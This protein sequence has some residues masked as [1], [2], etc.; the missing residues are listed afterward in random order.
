MSSSKRSSRKSSSRSRSKSKSEPSK[1]YGPADDEVK[2]GGFFPMMIGMTASLMLLFWVASLFTQ[3]ASEKKE[4][5]GER[6]AKVSA[7]LLESTSFDQFLKDANDDQVVARLNQL[8]NSRSPK[9]SPA[10]V[11]ESN[12]RILLC[13]RLLRKKSSKKYKKFAKL[14]WIDS[15]KSKYG[16]DFLGKMN[17]P[18]VSEEFE[19]CFSR[20]LNDTDQEVYREAH[21]ARVSHVL[22]ECIKG[23]R[24]A[25]DVSA[26]LSDTLKKFPGDD[27]VASIIRLQFKAAVE[28]D[29]NFAKQLAEDIL[30]KDGL[31]DEQ[32]AG[33]MQFV[34]DHYQIIKLNYDEMFINRFVNG[35]VGLRELQ[36]TSLQL[37]SNPEGGPLVVNKVS[38]VASWFER[39]R[40]FEIASEI[41]QAMADASQQKR[42]VAETNTLLDRIG[43]AGVKRMS[44]IGQEIP[45]SGK[46]LAGKQI[47]SGDFKGRV[48]LA[49]FFKPNQPQSTRM[50][51]LLERS[52]KKYA[53]FGSPV[54]VIAVPSNKQPFEDSLPGKFLSSPIHYLGWSAGQPSELVRAYPVTEFP[55][56]MAVDHKGNLAF[57]NLDPERYEHDIETLVDLR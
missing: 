5:S 50:L 44:S 27:R 20:F 29:I 6:S 40:Q 26:Y 8:K 28:S 22:F 11:T 30:R 56:L 15:E 31:K 39:R 48:I 24:S 45:I 19:A 7:F 17:A 53:E 51:N 9:L 41:Y 23:N 12:Q 43:S 33:F 13:K 32:T 3:S 25:E 54:R 38:E 37:L 35:D 57:T 1:A 21:L 42:S 2:K 52:A 47:D 10:K 14:Q 18:N 46:T 34:L 4:K 49:L 16:I 36:K 55:H